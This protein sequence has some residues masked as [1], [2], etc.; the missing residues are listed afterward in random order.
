MSRVNLMSLLSNGHLKLD[1]VTVIAA[2][3]GPKGIGLMECGS[4][5]VGI[6]L[7]DASKSRICDR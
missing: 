6:I 1:E 3:V 5:N 4:E 7:L 2:K